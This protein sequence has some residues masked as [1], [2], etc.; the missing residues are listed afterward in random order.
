MEEDRKAEIRRNA[1]AL[2]ERSGRPEG[3][4]QRFWRLAEA[5]TAFEDEKSHRQRQPSSPSTSKSGGIASGLQPSGRTPGG[6]SSTSLVGS[7]GTGG[8]STGGAATG[9]V[10]HED[11]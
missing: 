9:S 3:E 1:Y 5:D 10:K 8:G 6:G 7:V 4:D 11:D 2:W